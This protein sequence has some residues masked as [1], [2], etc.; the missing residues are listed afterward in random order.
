ML[1]LLGSLVLALLMGYCVLIA[2][3]MTNPVPIPSSPR[4]VPILTVSPDDH[5]GDE[6]SP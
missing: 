5:D 1:S 3:S 4:E 6:N 2:Y